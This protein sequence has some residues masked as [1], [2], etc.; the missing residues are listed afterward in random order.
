[1]IILFFLYQ[2]LGGSKENKTDQAYQELF[3]KTI[4]GYDCGQI[5]N[6]T[7]HKT[8]QIEACEEDIIH[9]VR[10]NMEVQILQKSDL[11]SQQAFTCSMRR[12]SKISHCGTYHHG[13]NL[14]S[15]EET[16]ESVPISQEECQSMHK[17]KSIKLGP[18]NKEKHIVLNQRKKI[19]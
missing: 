19:L 17:Y 9:K 5:Q 2:G 6:I 7:S 12:T 13:L 11:Y 10:T 4:I 16:Y 1:M 18:T 3:K 8:T 15:E 14:N